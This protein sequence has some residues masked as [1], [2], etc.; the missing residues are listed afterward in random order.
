MRLP[1]NWF[2]K[3]LPVYS[4]QFGSSQFG[5]TRSRSDFGQGRWPSR[6]QVYLG[7]V[8]FDAQVGNSRLGCEAARGV[9]RNQ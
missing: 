7:S 2:R 9:Y 5:G 1:A 6:P 4:S 3:N 8:I